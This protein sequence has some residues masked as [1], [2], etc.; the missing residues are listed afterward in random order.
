[1][2]KYINAW[3]S[4]SSMLKFDLKMKLTVFFAIVSLF[5]LKANDSYS[6]NTKLSLD[7]KKVTLNEVIREIES[8]SEFKFL[9]NRKDIELNRIVSIKAKRKRIT[10][11]LSEVFLGS[12][13]EFEV[14]HKQI[15]LTKSKVR[16]AGTA[17]R[18]QEREIKGT[19]KDEAGN[20]LPGASVIVK[21]TTNGV[22]TDFDG[23][24]T[25]NV[26]ADDDVLTISYI[27]HRS[28]DVTVAGQT[29]ISV[30]L[31]EAAAQL[32]EVVMVGSRGRPRT[33]LESVAPID[34][35]G[36]R[37]FEASPQAET[38]QIMQYAA[39][40]FHS[41][42]QNIGH[43]T[44]HVDPISLRGLG[45]DQT[46]VLINGKRRHASS[47]MNANGTVGRG[48]VGT[49]L[50][51]IPVAAIERIEVLR[52]GAAAQ[53]GSDAIAG[54]INIV[55]KKSVNKGEVRVT[56]GFLAA[57]PEAPSFLEDF[58]PYSGNSDLA[59]TRGEGGGESVQVSANYGVE[60]GEKGGFLNFTMNYLTRNPFN[61]MDDYTI[62]MFG[63]DDPRRGNAVAEFAAFNQSD[64]GAIAAYNAQFGDEFG[65]AVVNE[66][67]D[68]EG[69]RVANMGGS[70]TTNA[71]LVINTELPLS[72]NSTFYANV[73]YNYRLGSATGFVRRPNQGARQSGL[74][75]LGFSPHLDSDIQDLSGTIGLK[76]NFKGWDIDI[77]NDYGQN[78]FKWTIFNSNN[79]SL[80]LESPTSFDAGQLKYT[81][82]VMNFDIS[83]NHDV[84]FSLNTAFGSEF[85]L[86]NFKQFAGQEESWQ[87]YDGGI[88][89]AG[90]Q[91][92]PGYQPGN[93]TDEY[94]FNTAIY[95]DFEA[96]F[97]ESWLLTA[98]GR[99]ENYSDFGGRFNY[100]IGTRYKFGDLFAL[101]G[102][103]STGFRAPS[104]PQKFFSSFSLQFISLPDGTIDGVNIAHLTEDSFV[105]RQFGIQALKPETSRNISLGFTTR[106]FKGF[107]M[108]V[109]AYQIDIKDRI[110]ITGRFNGSQDPRFATILSNARLSQVQFMANAVDTKTKG[111]DFVMSYNIPFDSGSLTFTGAG[112]FTETKVPRNDAGDP[113]IKTGEF[114]RG[115]E[116]VLFNREEV[117]RIEVA[118]PTRKIIL[119]AIF[120]LNRFTMAANATNF[121]TVDYIHPIAAP[122]AN[123]WNNGA[124]ET[125]DQTFSAKTLVDLSLSFQLTDAFNIGVSGSNIFNVYPDRQTHSANYGGGMFAYSRR[126]SQFGLAGAGYNFNLSF[127]F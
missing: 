68:F 37:V 101:R 45:A 97:T 56:T 39:P 66:L 123:V 25:I 108:T 79:A 10:A 99:Y 84:G 107:S 85:R 122:I 52:D 104:L 2:K 14:L 127:K 110:G 41:T 75:P 36:T 46:L 7:V 11:I 74:W 67:N 78:S 103:Y 28:V 119:G 120:N 15:V 6:Q 60:V 63:E 23:N 87:N 35:I 125:L 43:G 92:F 22:Q 72:E 121:G 17:I 49:D 117:S 86:E 24:F 113:I 98:A 30:V 27:G 81:Q 21:G 16:P 106:P 59:S 100:K 12:D 64:P 32:E 69:R 4:N 1:M 62:Q 77:S 51:A 109:D 50:N 65:F 126:V 83:K 102:A 116:T 3:R 54:V 115:F 20:P 112:N 76:S 105:R 26:T 44:D 88:K 57:P 82:N 19:V 42:K 80:G 94:R 9:Y 90:S 47:L 96:E 58:N 89:E 73:M 118:Q 8:L 38:S 91:V 34:V 61:R 40:S 5:Q 95:A 70:G 31:K 53:Y 124:L 111:I 114:L 33:Q 13:I 29:N 71:G 55:L 18:E 93:A 48:Q